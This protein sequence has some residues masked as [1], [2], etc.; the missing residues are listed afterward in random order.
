MSDKYIFL[1]I[2]EM[3]ELNSTFSYQ[4]R[5]CFKI[6]VD[7]QID[8]WFLAKMDSLGISIILLCNHHLCFL[9]RL[10][11]LLHLKFFTFITT[12]EM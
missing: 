7:M 6:Y 11:V 2:F 10:F 8:K 5:I 4:F 9:E 3:D 1:E 12:D